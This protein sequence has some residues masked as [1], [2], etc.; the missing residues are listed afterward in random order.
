[1]LVV[2]V[3]VVRRCL[4]GRV[5]DVPRLLRLVLILL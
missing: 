1:M 4:V 2:V 5:W 3:V